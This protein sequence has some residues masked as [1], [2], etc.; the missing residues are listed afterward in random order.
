VGY[1]LDGAAKIGKF[2]LVTNVLPSG[3]VSMDL[4]K[5][6]TEMTVER[7]LIYETAGITGVAENILRY[8]AQL[9]EEREIARYA[10]ATA[11]ATTDSLTTGEMKELA[12]A[13]ARHT[14]KIYSAVVGGDDQFAIL[15][16]GEVQPATPEQ[17]V[18]PAGEARVFPFGLITGV[19][20]QGLPNGGGV[21]IANPV[22]GVGLYA[23]IRLIFGE[24]V[25][26]NGYYFSS[27]FEDQTIH[28]DGGI[29]E[30]DESN[31]VTNCTLILGPHADRHPE[32][33]AYLKSKFSWK[34]IR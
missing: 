32:F 15:E 13:L 26:D 23:H 25:L 22:D 24:T 11:S 12:S 5:Q 34:A 1:D 14:A 33:V 6:P 29:T 17:P 18:F 19:T 7:G 4:E 16:K 3:A 8:P 30:F 28:Y 2:V 10:K 20:L 31:K 27:E 9:S 21:L